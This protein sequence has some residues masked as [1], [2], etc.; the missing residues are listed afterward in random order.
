ML[1]FASTQVA[2]MSTAPMA[3]PIADKVET[4]L[5]CPLGRDRGVNS[6]TRLALPTISPTRSAAPLSLAGASVLNTTH[7][8]REH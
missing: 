3:A 7:S 1:G 6:P 5:N 4:H 2:R 8:A